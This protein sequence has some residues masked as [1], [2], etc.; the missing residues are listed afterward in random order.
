MDLQGEDGAWEGE[1]VWCPMLT[2]QY[3][4]LQHILGEPIESGRRRRIL[5]SFECTPPGG[6]RVGIA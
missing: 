5:R 4:L 1:M 6:R 3:V 2:A